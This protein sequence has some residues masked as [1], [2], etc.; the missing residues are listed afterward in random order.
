MGILQN[1]NE[2]NMDSL[3]T[4]K[5]SDT[6]TDT[7][8]VVKDINNP[9]TNN[10]NTLGL[11]AN[12]RVDDTS[13]IAQMLVSKPGLKFLANEALLKQTELTSKLGKGKIS[14][15]DLLKQVGGTAKHVLQVAASTLA[16]VPVNGT[17]THF[18]RG[19]NT[20]TRLLSGEAEASTFAELLGAGGVEGAPLA[21]IGSTIIPDGTPTEGLQNFSIPDDLKDKISPLLGTEG[22]A[23]ESGTV[24]PLDL[25]D[26]EGDN[27][28]DFENEDEQVAQSIDYNATSVAR[29]NLGDQGVKEETK[30]VSYDDPSPE[31]KRDVVN[32]TDVQSETV[33]EDDFV[34]LEFE[35]ITP[36]ESHFLQFRSFLTTL[37][38]NFSGNWNESKYLGRADSFYT[39]QGFSRNV[40]LGFIVA[41]AT[42]EEMKP[43][44]RKMTTLASVTAPTYGDS[45]KFMR[46]SLARITVGDYLYKVP[47]VIESVNFTWQKDYPWEIKAGTAEDMQVLPH[48]LDVSITFKVIHDF[49]PE[50]GIKPFIT[51]SKEIS[52]L[53]KFV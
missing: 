16:Q 15:Q 12:K 35:I 25:I 1:Y 39:Y 30:R 21:K 49:I 26:G 9:P 24:I 20:N 36:E 2:G 13:R 33:G 37:D 10:S 7:P 44:Y 3:R 31:L 5:H 6:G 41:A 19:F 43:L 46:G 34:Q 32:M 8:Y 47:G 18:L 45:G 11:Q 50:T 23:K 51:N 28:L 29:I 22:S 4:V 40:N 53:A 52:E 17:G 48:A 14:P 27:F 42:R 38:D